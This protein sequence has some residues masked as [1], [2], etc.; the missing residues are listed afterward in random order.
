MGAMLRLHMLTEGCADNLTSVR[1]NT[2]GQGAIVAHELNVKAAIARKSG[3]PLLSREDSLL[4]LAWLQ[5]KLGRVRMLH[6]MSV[7]TSL[8]R[9]RKVI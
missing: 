8:R 9:C 5:S 2:T 7:M 6:P 1:V 3:S 4:I